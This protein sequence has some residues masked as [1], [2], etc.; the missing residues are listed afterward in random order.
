MI[1]LIL[2]PGNTDDA[3]CMMF[4]TKAPDA[5]L[6]LKDYKERFPNDQFTHKI[7]TIKKNFCFDAGMDVDDCYFEINPDVME[8]E[9]DNILRVN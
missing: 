4:F 9:E 1:G 7:V 3:L 5:E 8:D 2:I 6:Y